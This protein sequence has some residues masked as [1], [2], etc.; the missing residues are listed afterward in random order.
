MRQCDS[1]N[2]TCRGLD[3]LKGESMK[4]TQTI[5][6]TTAALLTALLLVGCGTSDVDSELREPA[7]HNPFS[8]G[9]PAPDPQVLELEALQAETFEGR[10]ESELWDQSE[11]NPLRRFEGGAPAPDPQVLEL[12]AL[13]AETFETD[14][15]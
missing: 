9:T 4:T 2:R 7:E 5:A 13:Q 10:N 3:F 12:E 14:T 11:P 15:P 8:E 6:A 1:V